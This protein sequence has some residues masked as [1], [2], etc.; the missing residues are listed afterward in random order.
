MTTFFMQATGLNRP[1]I[2]YTYTR[3]PAC[4]HG[5]MVATVYKQM[6]DGK[7]WFRTR[8]SV[9]IFESHEEARQD[10][11]GTQTSQKGKVVL[12]PDEAQ[13][14]RCVELA[15]QKLDRQL[16]LGEAE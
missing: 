8:D 3:H 2:A 16:Y 1:V 4:P 5:A 13:V 12:H 14:R 6:P 9:H 15:L 10:F 7:G 11:F